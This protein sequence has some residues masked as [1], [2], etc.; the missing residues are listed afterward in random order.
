[1]LESGC[2]LEVSKGVS[3]AKWLEVELPITIV[4]A[5]VDNV[6]VSFDTFLKIEQAENT[7][8]LSKPRN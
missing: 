3:S 1:M 6:S 5:N 2:V 8:S 4:D 7:N